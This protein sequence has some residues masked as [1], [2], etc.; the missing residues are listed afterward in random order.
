MAKPREFIKDGKG[1]HYSVGAFIRQGGKYFLIDRAIAPLGFAGVAGH[2]DNGETAERAL[3]REIEEEVG[4]KI[5]TQKL[6]FEEFIDWN[7]C[8]KGVTGHYWYL[9]DCE[10]SGELKRSYRETKS[11]GWYSQDEI[12]TLKLEPVWDHWFKKLKII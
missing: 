9:F 1:F 6:I 4:L 10:V 5:V 11:A 2:L 7:W 12:K 3:I 8:S